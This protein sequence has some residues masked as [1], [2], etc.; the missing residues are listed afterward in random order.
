MLAKKWR[1]HDFSLS[2]TH[3]KWCC[4]VDVLPIKARHLFSLKSHSKKTHVN[5]CS[6]PRLFLSTFKRKIIIHFFTILYKCIALGTRVDCH[7][8]PTNF[9]SLDSFDM[10]SLSNTFGNVIFIGFLWIIYY[11]NDNFWAQSFVFCFWAKSF[12][13]ICI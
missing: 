13:S 10:E 6:N 8:P 7:A 11:I 3:I 1:L 5:S 4:L 2:N 12:F 9:S